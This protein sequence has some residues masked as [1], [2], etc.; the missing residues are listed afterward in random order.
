MDK[1]TIEGSPYS[2]GTTPIINSLI[3]LLT[4]PANKEFVDTV[5]INLGTL[6]RN[7]ASNEDV[8]S[9]KKTDKQAGRSTGKPT[10]IL[11]KEAKAEMERFSSDVCSIFNN[12]RNVTNPTV[13]MYYANY[14]PF[15]PEDLYREYTDGE[16]ALKE[17]DSWLKKEVGNARESVRV[18]NVVKTLLPITRNY[19]GYVGL[20]QELKNVMNEHS[21][22]MVSHHAMDYHL[23][24]ACSQFKLLDSYTGN[25]RKT[26]ELGQK[27]F[28]NKFL[29]FNR[30]LHAVLGDK[31]D[32]KPSISGNAKKDLFRVAE[33]ERWD[34]KSEN[35]IRTRLNQMH[36]TIPFNI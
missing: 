9:T 10:Q 15:I 13:I 34:T 32:I 19:P 28:S 14:F 3:D 25:V 35:Y 20:A 5:V 31:E 6:L 7:C 17:A 36:V 29:P 11:V 18:D 16:K 26:E 1:L 2:L 33:K 24:T 22:V 27:V 8:Q 4:H 30:C 12:A 21:V 23:W